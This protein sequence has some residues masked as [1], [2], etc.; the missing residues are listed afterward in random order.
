[1]ES[2]GLGIRGPVCL[3]TLQLSGSTWGK[4]HSPSRLP[5]SRLGEGWRWEQIHSP[6]HFFTA[7]NLMSQFL[8]LWSEQETAFVA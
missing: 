6:L 8:K 1:M 2:P 4:S 3:P 7:E 5:F